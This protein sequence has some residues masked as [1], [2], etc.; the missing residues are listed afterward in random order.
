MAADR[1]QRERL[2]LEAQPRQAAVIGTAAREAAADSPTPS[3][4]KPDKKKKSARP[5]KPDEFVATYASSA[6]QPGETK[7]K[8]AKKR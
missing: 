5:R 7:K 8:K 6:V 2:A 3:L 1:M 4:V